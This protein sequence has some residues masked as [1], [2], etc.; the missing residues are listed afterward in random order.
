MEHSNNAW[1][2]GVYTVFYALWYVPADVR[3]FAG[4]PLASV[5]YGV[6]DVASMRTSW[7]DPNAAFVG[8]KGGNNR[9]G[10]GHLDIGSFVYEVNGIRWALELGADDYNIPG[11]WDG[12]KRRWDIFR[13][14]SRSHNTLVI[15]DK[16]QNFAAISKIVSFKV[17]PESNVISRAVIDMTDAY[18]G[19]AK[20]VTRTVTLR[21]DGALVIEDVLDG[22]VETVRWGMMTGAAIAPGGRI[23]VLTERDKK[24]LIEIRANSATKFEVLSAAPPTPRE[25][26]NKGCSML[27]AFVKPENGKVEIRVLLKKK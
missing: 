26:Q 25:I 11:Y 17:F 12:K 4:K 2:H 21:K 6:Q 27:A 15:G 13:L 24:L 3:A 1:T 18:K 5:W 8:L 23:A 9:A 7:T 19:Q 16:L 22:V 10:H 14:N 20:S